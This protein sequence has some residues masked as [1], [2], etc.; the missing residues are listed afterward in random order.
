MGKVRSGWRVPISYQNKPKVAMVGDGEL[1]YNWESRRAEGVM[2][3]IREK[4]NA[5]EGR[6]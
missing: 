2:I 5:V 3:I 4:G 1:G 6:Y